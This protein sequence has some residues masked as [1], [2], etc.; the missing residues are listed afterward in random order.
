MLPKA[1]QTM[2]SPERAY[3]ELHITYVVM[4]NDKDN[5]IVSALAEG[6][7]CDGA[8]NDGDEIEVGDLW[9]IFS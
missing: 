3:V 5:E 7:N 2:R 6:V 4:H 1:I 9:I 8:A